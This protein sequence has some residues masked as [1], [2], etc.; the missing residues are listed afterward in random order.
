MQTWSTDALGLIVMQA[1]KRQAIGLSS[2]TVHGPSLG[3]MAYTGRAQGRGIRDARQQTGPQAQQEHARRGRSC[4]IIIF[5]GK[6][7]MGRSILISCGGRAAIEASGGD[8]WRAIRERTASMVDRRLR[9]EHDPTS[10]KLI[11]FGHGALGQ[12]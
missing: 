7:S 5:I 9:L 8:D 10:H 4:E 2:M 12:G 11:A 3:K 6:E 1:V